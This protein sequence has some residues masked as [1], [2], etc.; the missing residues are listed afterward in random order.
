MEKEGETRVEIDPVGWK[1][2]SRWDKHNWGVKLLESR[3][4]SGGTTHEGCFISI[5]RPSQLPRTPSNCIVREKRGRE[6]NAFLKIT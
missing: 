5:Y 1:V 4:H 2:T 6:N 3:E